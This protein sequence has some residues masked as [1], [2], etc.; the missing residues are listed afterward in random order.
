[1]PFLAVAEN[2]L[3]EVPEISCIVSRYCLKA[4]SYYWTI[5]DAYLG[6]P[7]SDAM[8]LVNILFVCSKD[9]NNLLIALIPAV[10]R[11]FGVLGFW[12]FGVIRSRH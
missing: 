2:Y 1:M 3:I 7:T 8:R 6:L 12:G 9:E 4:A 11:G 5:A 10:P